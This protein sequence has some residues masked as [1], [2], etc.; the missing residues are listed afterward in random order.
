MLQTFK[1]LL[2]T[3]IITSVYLLLN[4]KCFVSFLCEAE[5]DSSHYVP[6]LTNSYF[7]GQPT[8][9]CN[10]KHNRFSEKK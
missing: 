4:L 2:I 3:M 1:F 10:E 8:Q 9:S 6:N 5:S 7:Y